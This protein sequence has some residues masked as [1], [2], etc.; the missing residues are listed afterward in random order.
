VE[1]VLLYV[2]DLVRVVKTRSDYRAG[3]ATVMIE[4]IAAGV[5]RGKL[6]CGVIRWRL[7]LVVAANLD[8]DRPS[9]R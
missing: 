5:V 1:I 4:S 3:A 2:L 7:L 6:W 9:K 8:A